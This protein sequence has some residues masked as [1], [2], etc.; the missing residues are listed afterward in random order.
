M[1]KDPPQTRRPAFR[2]PS[3]PDRVEEETNSN[4]SPH[5]PVGN[6]VRGKIEQNP[7]QERGDDS[8][9]GRGCRPRD[10]QGA[11]RS[12]NSPDLQCVTRGNRESRKNPA[13]GGDCL[14]QRCR[15]L[16][17]QWSAIHAPMADS[18]IER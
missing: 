3:S 7:R 17:V 15:L 1:L 9:N 13:V 6:C 14:T 2:I 16:F 10:L 18:D 4:G 11:I 12:Q 8:D 5:K